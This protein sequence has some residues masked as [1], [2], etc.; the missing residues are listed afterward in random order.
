MK[1]AYTS[2]KTRADAPPPPLQ[3]PPTPYFPFFCLSTYNSVIALT[4][5]TEKDWAFLSPKKKK[6]RL[7]KLNQEARESNILTQK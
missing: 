7:A 3:T 6:H 4:M 5:R 1:E 2:S